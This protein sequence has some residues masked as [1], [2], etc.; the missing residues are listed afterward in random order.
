MPH[1]VSRG[2]D[3]QVVTNGRRSPRSPLRRAAYP[4]RYSA[5][6]LLRRGL[7]HSEWPPAWRAHPMKCSYHVVIVGGRVHGLSAA[8]YLTAN[9]VIAHLATLDKVYMACDVSARN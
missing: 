3:V 4:A 1:R 5:R 8:Y 2:G 7:T 9:H 6:G